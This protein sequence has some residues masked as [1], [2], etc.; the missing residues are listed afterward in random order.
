MPEGHFN[1]G[2]KNCVAVDVVGFKQQRFKTEILFKSNENKTR[3]NLPD[4]NSLRKS[5]IRLTGSQMYPYLAKPLQG[6]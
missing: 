2:H 5:C 1:E 4:F 3:K 6:V